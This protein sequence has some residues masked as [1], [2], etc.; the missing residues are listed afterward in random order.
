MKAYIVKRFFESLLTVF[1]VVVAVF[2]LLRFMPTDGYFDRDDYTEMS[3]AAR[4]AYLR[5][6]GLTDNP[7]VQL[8]RFVVNLAQ[9]DWG[10]S[11]T[12]YPRTSISE[13]LLEKIP[14]SLSFGLSAI[15][16][17]IVLGLLMGILMAQY[18]D[19]I[20]DGVGTAY[21]V[22]V[23]AIPSLIYLFLIQIWV[24]KLLG[25]PM[26]FNERNP[27]SWILPAISLALPNIAWYAIWLRRFMVDE[28]N[29]DYIKFAV[30]KGVPRRTIMFK[31]VLR[32]AAVPLVQYLPSQI[33]LTVGGSLII[34][35]IYSIPGLGGLLVYAIRQQDNPLVQALVLIFSVLG[36]FGVFMG[37]V[38]MVLVDPRIKLGKAAKSGG[39][40]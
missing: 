38:L 22:L 18:K 9:G 3:E 33:L 24:T 39:H 10:R 36:I 23:R 26:L 7:L 32:N 5:T 14:Y 28:E 1:F 25:W 35:S 37:D 31:H 19:G 13:I 4:N 20:V 6:L 34:E 16:I 29:K 27:V 21:V 15:S 40:A 17:S 8:G 30:S 11:I 2:M 12:V